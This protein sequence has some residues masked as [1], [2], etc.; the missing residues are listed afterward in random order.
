M[1]NG[2]VLSGPVVNNGKVTF[3]DGGI[4][5]GTLTGSGAV[6]VTGGGVVQFSNPTAVTISGIGNVGNPGCLSSRGLS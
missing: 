6:I 5:T 3:V 1:V 4:V 2:G